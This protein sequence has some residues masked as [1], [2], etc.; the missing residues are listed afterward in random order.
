V[1]FRDQLEGSCRDYFAIDGWAHYATAGSHWLWVSRDAPLVI[2][3]GPHTLARRTAEPA[4]SHRLMAMIFDNF[5]HTNFVADSHGE[6]EFQFELTW[7]QQL[8]EAAPLAETLTLDP[9]VCINPAYPESRELLDRL[10]RP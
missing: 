1:P 5:W 9:V 7:R 3:G 6:M 8:A 10:F 4:D 2:V